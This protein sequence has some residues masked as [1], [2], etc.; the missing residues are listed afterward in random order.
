MALL[1]VFIPSGLAP[2]VGTSLGPGLVPGSLEVPS[3]GFRQLPLFISLLQRNQQGPQDGSQEPG[4]LAGASAG[5]P[6]H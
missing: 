1:W 3:A 5:V 2:L 6:G 4:S